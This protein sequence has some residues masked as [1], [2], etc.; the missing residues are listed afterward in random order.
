MAFCLCSL[1]SHCMKLSSLVTLAYGDYTTSYP[2]L[3]GDAFSS[4]G[5]D[6]TSMSGTRILQ[7][8][9]PRSGL[10]PSTR[11]LLVQRRLAWTTPCGELLTL[12]VMVSLNG[13]YIVNERSRIYVRLAV[14]W[15]MPKGNDFPLDICILSQPHPNVKCYLVLLGAVMGVRNSVFSP[16]LR[17]SWHKPERWTPR[18]CLWH[19]PA[20]SPCR[21]LGS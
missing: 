14:R 4:V 2:R 9:I 11:L 5:T 3:Y 18:V 17:R 8:Y 6:L 10:I 15:A 12:K 1:R 21:V 16:L 13:I 19:R 20:S 7:R